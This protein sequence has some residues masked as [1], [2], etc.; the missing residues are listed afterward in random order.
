MLYAHKATDP[1]TRCS[2]KQQT[3]LTD[4]RFAKYQNIRQTRYSVSP[5]I[6]H[7]NISKHPTIIKV[8]QTSIHPSPSQ[9]SHQAVPPGSGSNHLDRHLG[10]KAPG[11]SHGE[12]KRLKQRGLV[13]LKFKGQQNHGCI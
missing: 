13:T 1:A 9:S 6:K 8:H 10:T 3:C 11:T 12:P 5:S 2:L 4:V 7:P